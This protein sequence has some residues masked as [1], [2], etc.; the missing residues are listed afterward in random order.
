MWASGKSPQSAWAKSGGDLARLLGLHDAGC[1]VVADTPTCYKAVSVIASRH[2][3]DASGWRDY[4]ARAKA[5][6]YSSLHIVVTE[7]ARRV[8]VQIRTDS[9]HHDARFGRAAHWAYKLG[10]D[11]EPAW[12]CV[13][14]GNDVPDNV[15]VYTPRPSDRAAARRLRHR[16]RPAIHSN[17]GATC[18]GARINGRCCPVNSVGD[19]DTVECGDRQ[20]GPNADWLRWWSPARAHQDPASTP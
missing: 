7:D 19:G 8:E 16:L 6:G 5:S 12:L 3:F 10:S 13:L 4:V 1:P 11:G 9:M 2:D 18:V 17:V 14:A 15:T 20:A